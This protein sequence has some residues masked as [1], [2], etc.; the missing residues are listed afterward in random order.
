MAAGQH[1]AERLHAAEDEHDGARTDGGVDQ[2]LRQVLPLEG[3]IDIA[4]ADQAVHGRNRAALGRGKDAAVNAAQN[5]D[6]HDQRPDA[7]EEYGHGFLRGHLL[8]VHLDVGILLDVDVGVN[9]HEN[10]HQNA[11]T[12]AGQEQ[13]A[14]GNLSQNSVRNHADA[15]RDDLPQRTGRG[16][17]GKAEILVIAILLHF[18]RHDAADSCG[19]RRGRT[20]NRREERAGE[21]RHIGESALRFAAEQVDEID[22]FLAQ[23]AVAHQVTA[24]DEQRNR[25][26]LIGGHA[27]KHRLADDHHVDAHAAHHDGDNSCETEA[28][29]NRG[30]D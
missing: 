18:R 24:E 2:N 28:C 5:D 6:R 27:G 19:R 7:L 30:T 25:H 13:R 8:A 26:Q 20:G 1:D 10:S 17:G 11:W 16:G 4:A 29:G 14:D 3:L 15:R 23:A 22:E 21:N 12:E 9:E